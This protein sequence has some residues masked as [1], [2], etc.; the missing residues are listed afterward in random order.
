[1]AV[2]TEIFRAWKSP[3]AAIRRQL[4]GGENEGRAL[5]YLMVACLLI[6][7]AQWPRLSREAFLQPEIPLDVRIGGA[8]MG[9][10]FIAPLL[11]YG[12]A[13]LSHLI[14]RLAGGQG[15]YF[16]ARLALFWSLL[17]ISPIVLFLGLV[18]GFIGAGPAANA[19]SLLLLLAFLYI[20][21]SSLMEAERPVPEPG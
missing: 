18:A 6:F 5:I 16:G 14:S 2:T 11:F 21:G 10:V 3:R 8:L 20:W 1:M 4:A 19:T 13:A 15:S 12:L 17:V 7:I 9:W